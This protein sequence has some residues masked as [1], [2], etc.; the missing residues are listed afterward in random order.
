VE[1]A[2]ELVEPGCRDRHGLPAGPPR[3][4]PGV[5]LLGPYR[6]SGLENPPYLVRRG[7]TVLQVSQLLLVVAA[8]ADGRRDYDE[9]AAVASAQLRRRLSAED[10][11]YLIKAK[12]APAGIVVPDGETVERPLSPPAV[13]KRLLALRFR[14]AVVPPEFVEGAARLLSEL[15]RPPVVAGV[16]AAVIAF[17]GWLFGVHGVQAALDQVV[18]QSGLL[19]FVLALTCLSAAFHEFGHA[20]GCRYSGARPG[21]VGAGIYLFWPVLYTNVTDSYRLG[22]IGRL[23]T[24]LG[25]IYFNAVFIAVLGGVYAATG[26]EPL[27]AAAVVQH[28]LILDQ[29]MPWFRFDGY[30]VISD[31]TGVPDILDRVRPALRSLI[32]GQPPHP[33]IVALRPRARRLLFAYL[34]SLIVFVGVS[35]VSLVVQG[36]AL[37]TG[38]WDSLPSHVDALKTA[39]GMWDL[40]VA[41]L[42]VIQIGLLAAPAVG[43][44]LSLGFLVSRAVQARAR[45][46]ARR[47][48]REDHSYRSASTGGSAAARRA[49]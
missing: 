42:V 24:D 30:Y 46:W 9:M 10:V 3:L 19:P 7:G 15:F 25:G 43:F 2:L 47:R 36:P 26:Y 5:E 33:E 48:H 32:P 40:P 38:S 16:V 27:V 37:L 1:I 39:V 6:D 20:A 12:L 8:A 4:E 49:G 29:L 18:R 45:W 41:V 13:D 14:W 31:L 35:L 17:D 34:G 23:R 22:R 21:A 28:V 11:R 44:V